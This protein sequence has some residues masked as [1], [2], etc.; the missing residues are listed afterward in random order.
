MN[1][2]VDTYVDIRSAL[3]ETS[4]NGLFDPQNISQ[5]GPAIVIRGRFSLTVR[6]RERLEKETCQ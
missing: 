4:A 6:P 3:R 2:E 1:T 5:L